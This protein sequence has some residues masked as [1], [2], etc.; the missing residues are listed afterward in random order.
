MSTVQ[1]L[2]DVSWTPGEVAS[3]TPSANDDVGT[4]A[5]AAYKRDGVVCLRG[6]FEQQWLDKLEQ[7]IDAVYKHGGVNGV[8]IKADPNDPGFFYYDSVMWPHIEEFREFIFDSHAPDLFRSLLQTDKLF[9][10]YDF[11][12]VKNAQCH[13]S[14][15][16]WHHDI[17][18]YPLKGTQIANCWT[19]LD[20]IPLETSLRFIKSSNRSDVVHQATHF[21]PKSE[22]PNLIKSRPKVPDVDTMAATGDVEVLACEMEPGDTVVFNCRTLH[23]APGNH[24]NNRRA[25]FSTNWVGDDVTYSDMAQT[26]DPHTRG[27]NLVDGGSI[28]CKTF[29]RV[30]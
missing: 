30:R 17:A 4:Q 20:N 28:E 3:F 2:K 9:F 6:T 29:P 18:Y 14:A 16:P 24:L 27:E 10:Y 12:I 23:S 8:D 11:L 26:S 5:I 19:A 22:Y 25:A 15:T 7:G 21:N 13:R 1:P